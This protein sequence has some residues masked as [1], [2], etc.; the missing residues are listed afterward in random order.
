[1]DENEIL[2]KA[3]ERSGLK[4]GD[5]INPAKDGLEYWAFSQWAP[6]NNPRDVTIDKFI[7]S[8]DRLCACSGSFS[9]YAVDALKAVF[10]LDEHKIASRRETLITTEKSY[11]THEE[12]FE[13]NKDKF[14]ILSLGDLEQFLKDSKIKLN[15]KQQGVLTKLVTSKLMKIY[16]NK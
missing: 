3:I 4:I 8:H 15:I 16:S 7:M 14:L 11:E 13:D 10:V 2:Q 1:M 6:S 9:P 5:T 12:A